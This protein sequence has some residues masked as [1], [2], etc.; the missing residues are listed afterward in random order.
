MN[1]LFKFNLTNIQNVSG[2]SSWKSPSNI[3]L[4]KYWGKKEIQIP[5]NASLS[6]TLSNCYTECSIK[7]EPLIKPNNQCNFELLFEGKREISFEEKLN[8]F[9]KRIVFYCPYLIDLKLTIDTK[10]SFP[11]SSGIASSAS[12]YSA[13]SLCIMDIEKKINPTISSEYFFNKASF[14]SRLG[15]GSASRSVLGPLAIWG[16]SD[17]FKH[18]SNFFAVKYEEKLH[19]NFKNIQDTI[20][21]VDKGKK[22][23]SSTVGHDLMINHSF[24]N[25]RLVQVNQNL[26]L[27]KNAL[28]SGD[29][30]AFTHIVELEALTLHAMMMTSSPYYILIKPNTLNIINEIW[31]YRKNTNSKVC[32]TLDAGA[33]IHLLYPKK[34]FNQIQDFISNNLSKFCQNGEFI[35]DHVGNGPNKL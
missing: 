8:I 16:E 21:L 22:H 19:G 27:L 15:S 13:L 33:N 29:F 3:A 30:E 32:F 28:I 14:L 35:N 23:I 24:S 4:I 17:F 31:N 25:D 6:F 5:L 7:Y 2:Q 9:F 12:A 1:S 26:K 10:N 34:N 11:H 20:L 18:S